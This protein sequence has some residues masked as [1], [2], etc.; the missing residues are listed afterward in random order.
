M[1]ARRSSL[2]PE[3]RRKV[4]PGLVDMSVD[5]GT[6][7]RAFFIGLAAFAL[8]G[9]PFKNQDL[10][11][12][13]YLLGPWV[14]PL[15]GALLWSLRPARPYRGEAW[16]DKK[17]VDMNDPDSRLLVELFRSEAARRFVWRAALRISLTLFAITGTAAILERHWL[18]WSLE[19]PW[20]WPGVIGGSIS[21]W[22][23]LL[24]DYNRWVFKNWLNHI[25]DRTSVEE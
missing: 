6:L 1:R 11:G 18:T 20:L 3:L 9:P 14:C 8:Y 23:A 15:P 25:R 13:R 24:I 19:S 4:S 10:N 7:F 12:V 21:S 22:L 17:P 16:S 2:P 5:H